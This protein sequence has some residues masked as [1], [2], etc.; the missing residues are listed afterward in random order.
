MTMKALLKCR[1]L[2]IEFFIKQIATLNIFYCS[3]IDNTL[4]TV[5]KPR[6]DML[7]FSKGE[8]I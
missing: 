2:F 3:K 7:L 4:L 8:F 6:V 1:T 5:N